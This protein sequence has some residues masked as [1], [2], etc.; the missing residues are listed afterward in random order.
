MGDLK[1]VRLNDEEWQL[2]DMQQDLT[3]L[4]NLAEIKPDK[5]A[6]LVEAYENWKDNLPK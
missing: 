1:L 3:E 2:Y 5:V 4:E 6:D